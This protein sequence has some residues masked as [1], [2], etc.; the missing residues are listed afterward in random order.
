MLFIALSLLK[1]YP[2][3]TCSVVC[4]ENFNYASG[5]GMDYT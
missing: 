5:V 2:F 4:V 1:S 3:G